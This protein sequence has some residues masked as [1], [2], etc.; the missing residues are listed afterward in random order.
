MAGLRLRP[1][2]TASLAAMQDERSA[3]RPTQVL[4]RSA[5]SIWLC[6]LSDRSDNEHDRTDSGKRLSPGHG[7]RVTDTFARDIP[8]LGQPDPPRSTPLLM[9]GDHP[10]RTPPPAPGCPNTGTPPPHPI[11]GTDRA[12]APP[13]SHRHSDPIVRQNAALSIPILRHL[14]HP[15]NRAH[16]RPPTAISYPFAELQNHWNLPPR[17]VFSVSVAAFQPGLRPRQTNRTSHPQSLK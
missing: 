6:L 3:Q 11:R 12:G 1:E 9:V 13:H 4:R 7:R 2:L 15:P 5:K 14:H 10:F 17:Y 8:P 16:K